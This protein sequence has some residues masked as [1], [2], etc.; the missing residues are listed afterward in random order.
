[1]KKR[2]RKLYIL[3]FTAILFIAVFCLTPPFVS[4]VTAR[5]DDNSSGGYYTFYFKEFNVT[6]DVASDRKISVREE[7]TVCYTG[8]YSTGFIRDIPTNG[9][10]MVRNVNVCE[11]LSGVEKPVVYYVEDYS[12][13]YDNTYISANIGDGTIKTNEIRT[14]VLTYD[15]CL[16]KAQE[17]EN[18]LELNIIGPQDR[19]VES[20]NAKLILPDGFISGTY[21]AGKVGSDDG[22]ELAAVTEN[23][24]K[25]IYLNGV[26]LAHNEGVSVMLNFEDGKLT[27]YSDFTPYLVIIVAACV[28]LIMLA[29]KFLFFNKRSLMPVV[30]F[31]APNNMDPLMMGKLIDNTVDTED[32]TS[33]IFYWADKGYLKINIENEKNPTLIRIVQQLPESSPAYEKHLFNDLFA[34][35]D[36]VNPND[37]PASYYSTIQSV[38]RVIDGRAKGLYEKTS[39]AASVAFT[40]AFAIILA[41]TP[42]IMGITQIHYT[43]LLLMPVLFG[44]VPFPLIY[45]FS[46]QIVYNRLKTSKQAKSQRIICVAIIAGVTLIDTFFYALLV[47]ASVIGTL[48]KILMLWATCIAAAFA[49][50]LIQRTEKYNAQ[51]NEI[52]GFKKF[53]ELAE[54]DRLE[55][56]IETD[57]QF[58]YHVLPYAQVLGVSD[59]WEEKFKN[60]AM[61]PPAYVTYSGAYS[62]FEF[63]M[64]NKIMR[65]SALS[66]ASHMAPPKNSGFSS[67]GG[68][69]RGGFGGGFVGGGH[70][71]GGSRGR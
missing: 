1:M 27:V 16:T 21:S 61:A 47:P 51:L 69:G 18:A 45:F 3:I 29:A 7:M 26:S 52:T 30:N 64:I 28:F 25:V 6:Y 56:M 62:L 65:N 34:G 54:K 71:G 59:K 41:L 38:K 42:L 48:P 11:V 5:A 37:V 60:I 17:G 9:G 39:I 36:T 31:E 15:Y 2:Y 46:R 66:F 20:F 33:M 55:K 70:G 4:S 13:D 58:Y 53:I 14:Y 57:P 49:P 12:D 67:M 24:R 19:R 43:Y 63:H 10:E 22:G 44:I 32:I 50:C 40:A 23:G 35:R 68:S 8:Y